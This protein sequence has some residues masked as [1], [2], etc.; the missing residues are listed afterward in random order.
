MSATA[1]G[2]LLLIGLLAGMLSGF[3]GVGG[4]IIMV[5][6]LVWLMGYGQHQAQG[7]SLAVLVLPVVAIAAWNYHRQHPLDL[8]A[9]GLI[10]GAFVLGGYLGSRMALSIPA[11][12][13]KRVFGLVMLVAALKLILGK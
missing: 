12:A 5:P 6:A 10:A 3:V 1:V 2:L 11:D 9:V 8:R 4:G 7:T 13:V